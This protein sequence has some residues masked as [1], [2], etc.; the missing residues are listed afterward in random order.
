MNVAENYTEVHSSLELYMPALYKKDL[1]PAYVCLTTAG[2]SK[3][4]P[5]CFTPTELL[6]HTTFGSF[7]CF[8]D[9]EGAA[10]HLS[11]LAL[12]T[13]PFEDPIYKLGRAGVPIFPENPSMFLPQVTYM[14]Q[15][16]PNEGRLRNISGAQICIQHE[17]GSILGLSRDAVLNIDNLLH[18]LGYD[19]TSFHSEYKPAATETPKYVQLADTWRAERVYHQHLLHL[20]TG[21]SD[22]VTRFHHVYAIL[23]E[24]L[25]QSIDLKAS[26]SK[27]VSPTGFSIPEEVYIEEASGRLLHQL[28]GFTLSQL[29][30]LVVSFDELRQTVVRYENSL[31]ST[32]SLL[33]QTIPGGSLEQYLAAYKVQ[34]HERIVELF[35]Q[36]IGECRS[37]GSARTLSLLLEGKDISVNS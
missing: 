21:C 17:D 4:V 30:E 6:Q 14:Q 3:N 1:N 33:T 29:G 20:P 37:R 26:V 22:L 9:E 23:L 35:K 27:N 18:M 36:S 28:S 13:S 15:G 5:E 10:V 31:A 25:T 24:V 7:L 34:L 2:S 19:S 16:V 11:V 8:K 12:A 32:E